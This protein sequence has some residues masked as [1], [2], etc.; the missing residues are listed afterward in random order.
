[1][2]GSGVETAGWPRVARAAPDSL[3]ARDRRL[4]DRRGAGR[5]GAAAERRAGGHRFA[6]GPGR[7]RRR[8]DRRRGSFGRALPLPGA[9]SHRRRR[10]RPAAASAASRR[11]RSCRRSGPTSAS[12]SYPGSQR[13]AFA[14]LGHRRRARR[15]ER[16]SDAGAA[17]TYLFFPPGHRSGGPHR[18]RRALCRPRRAAGGPRQRSGSPA[19]FPLAASRSAASATRCRW[20]SSPR[21]CWSRSPSASTSARCSRR[22][23]T[24]SRSRLAYMLAVRLVGGVGQVVGISVPEEVEP[25]MVALLFGIVTDYVIFFLSRFRGSPP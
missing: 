15:I 13:F 21:S 18:A 24:W 7:Q 10:A 17:L 5:D 9:E 14:L 16:G 20:S 8:R 1:M 19:P 23:P 12:A 22:S 3:P 6:R 11:W 4:L 2:T 25:V